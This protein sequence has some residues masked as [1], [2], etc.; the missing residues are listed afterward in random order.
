[1]PYFKDHVLPKMNSTLNS[2]LTAGLSAGITATLTNAAIQGVKELAPKLGEKAVKIIGLAAVAF[3]ARLA[4]NLRGAP[5]ELKPLA[6]GL[7]F[8]TCVKTAVEILTPNTRAAQEVAG[9]LVTSI[10]LCAIPILRAY[11]YLSPM[12]LGSV[13]GAH[14]SWYRP[15]DI[16]HIIWKSAF[17]AAAIRWIFN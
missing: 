11:Q 2:I 14:L 5:R 1:M 3:A 9:T 16:F 13:L 8:T 15:T 7:A 10:G 12:T 6:K 17:S 4:A